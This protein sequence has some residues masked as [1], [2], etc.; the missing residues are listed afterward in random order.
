MSIISCR[1]KYVDVLVY[2]RFN[3]NLTNNNQKLWIRSGLGWTWSFNNSDIEVDIFESGDVQVTGY[4]TDLI[5]KTL[6]R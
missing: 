3:T 5:I 1:D 6:T 2:G 4:P